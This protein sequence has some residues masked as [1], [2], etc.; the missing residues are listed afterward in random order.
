MGDLH[1]DFVDGL[2]L[3]CT[4]FRSEGFE[5]VPTETREAKPEW[6]AFDEVPYDRMWADDQYWLP[7]MLKGRR[8]R[9][10]FRFDNEEMLSRK[11]VFRD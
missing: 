10:W 11:V 1:F 3:Y 6:F 7:E 8:F 9:A 5:G 4:V 2:K